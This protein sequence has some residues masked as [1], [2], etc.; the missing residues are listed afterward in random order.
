MPVETHLFVAVDAEGV[1]RRAYHDRTQA[2]DA[3]ESTAYADADLVSIYP[4]VPVIEDPESPGALS[5]RVEC[6]HCAEPLDVELSEGALVDRSHHGCL[7]EAPG[8][9]AILDESGIKTADGYQ[10]SWGRA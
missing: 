8:V 10:I 4:D 7:G 6:E 3:V 1:P 9:V 2:W 5:V